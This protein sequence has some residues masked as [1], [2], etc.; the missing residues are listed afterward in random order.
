MNQRFAIKLA[1]LGQNYH[2]F[3]RQ[4]APT[5]TIERTILD[6]LKKLNIISKLSL[7]RYSAAGRTDRGVN[8]L[9]QV[10]AFDSLKDRIHLEELNQSLPDDIY[11]WGLAK[12][13][14]SFNARRDAIKRIYR[15]YHPF[16]NQDLVLMKQSLKRLEGKH[17]FVKLCKKPDIL[18]N[19]FQKSTVLT[20]EKA[21][22]NFDKKQEILEFEF[23]S[24]SFLWN[25]VRKMVS[26]VLDISS[27]KHNIEIIDDI[28][29]PE[30]SKLNFGLK[31]AAPEG[32]VLYDIIYPD[33]D[34]EKI[35]KKR[36]IGYHLTKELNTHISLSQVLTLM[37]NSI[38]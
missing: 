23:T 26:L 2:G 8:A 9:S 6:V 4:K 32:L 34:F 1:Y 14:E 15:Y 25:Q 37:K 21:K 19:G 31:S 29:D 30:S 18:P 24:R 5:K 27:G 7:V 13:P 11:A 12:V 38:L 33:L 20:L 28:L 10:I 16:S 22:V 36:V 35:E 3:Q 17:D